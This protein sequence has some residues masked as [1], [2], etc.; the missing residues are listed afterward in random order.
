MGAAI[1]TVG[2]W[3]TSGGSAD[4]T[5]LAATVSTGDSATVRNFA[6]TA[7]ATLEGLLYQAAT[8]GGS[9]RARSPLFH[10]NNRGIMFSP[11]ESPA[12]LLLP[13]EVSQLLQPQDTL[14]LEML[15]NA[16]TETD[17]GA[18]CIYYSDLLGAAPRLYHW[19]D[20][21]GNVR[22]LKPLEVDV[23]DNATKGL[24][25]DAIINT[26]EN[27]LQA[28]RDY[29][30]LGYIV[31]QPCVAVAI[32]GSDTSNLRI[33]GPGTVRTPDTADY[34]VSMAEDLGIPHIPVIN[35]AN[36]GTTSVSILSAT[37]GTTHKVQ[38][39][40]AEMVTNLS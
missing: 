7:T 40:L 25:Q 26:T 11:G 9:L 38:L 32:K 10:D 24:W 1:D 17:V 35:S 22:C 6:T 31:D 33:A 12:Q 36:A 39:V 27:L 16:A 19:G 13:R 23:T 28:N 20:I 4:S 2:F 21:S 34:F 8:A 5:P 15:V 37:T 3:R 18:L 14:T 30:V 29:A